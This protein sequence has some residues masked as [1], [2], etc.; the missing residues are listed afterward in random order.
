MATKFRRSFSAGPLGGQ[1]EQSDDRF[2]VGAQRHGADRILRTGIFP[3]EEK[4]ADQT[5]S[6]VNGPSAVGGRELLRGRIPPSSDILSERQ[7]NLQNV[8]GFIFDT[9]GPDRIFVIPGRRVQEHQTRRLESETDRPANLFEFQIRIFRR[10]QIPVHCKT[11]CSQLERAVENQISFSG[12]GHAGEEQKKKGEFHIDG[13]LSCSKMVQFSKMAIHPGP[14][15]SPALRNVLLSVPIL[16]LTT[17]P[18]TLKNGA[19]S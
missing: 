18:E 4:R 3:V 5:F 13:I 19:R 16:R 12:G 10:V 7:R 14:Y 9:I 6:I 11:I 8:S 17:A 15:F 2:A 1:S